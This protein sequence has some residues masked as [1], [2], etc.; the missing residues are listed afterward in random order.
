MKVVAEK[1]KKILPYNFKRPDRISK[2]QLR[3]LHFIHDRFARNFSTSLSAYLRTVVEVSLEETKQLLYADFIAKTKDPTCFAA[4]SLRPLD[5]SAAVELE[6]EIVF[7][8]LERLL[9]GIGRPGQYNRPLTEIEQN[10]IQAVL[11]L[12][13]DNLKESWRPM[14]AIEF[15]ASAVEVHPHLVQQRS[16]IQRHRPCFNISGRLTQILLYPAVVAPHQLLTGQQT[17]D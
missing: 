1:E 2:N 14:F 7:P 6:P 16:L 11:K 5:G 17:S 10:I 4:L 12:L 15:A 8:V 13:V 9:G 3:S